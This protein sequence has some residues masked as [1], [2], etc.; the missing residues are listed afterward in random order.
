MVFEKACPLLGHTSPQLL[1]EDDQEVFLPMGSV[2]GGKGHW[3][4]LLRG[5]AGAA[6]CVAG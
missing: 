3:R 1:G 4:N 6:V 5:L 2:P